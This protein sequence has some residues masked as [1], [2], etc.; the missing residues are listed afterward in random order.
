MGRAVGLAACVIGL[1]GAW[2]YLAP[3]DGDRVAAERLA[4]V[5][6]IAVD[7]VSGAT[8]AGNRR[9]RA[10]TGGPATVPGGARQGTESAPAI[11]VAEVGGGNGSRN[12]KP[13]D[14]EARRALV[15]SM[16]A[17][18]KRVGC[19]DGEPD[20]QWTVSTRRAMATFTERVNASLPTAEPD[21][22]LLTLLQG[23][24]GRVCGKGCPAGQIAGADGTCTPR[25]VAS[26]GDRRQ[27]AGSAG[28]HGYA[29]QPPAVAKARPEPLPGRMALAAPMPAEPGE[30]TDVQRR[31]ERAE[32]QGADARQRL[33][34]Q[35]EERRARIEA[36]R[37]RL[38]AQ[39]AQ[40]AAAKEEARQ[41]AERA[42]AEAA[43]ARR[44][45]LAAAEEQRA[46]LAQ[47]VRER[48]ESKGRPVAAAERMPPP[49]PAGPKPGEAPL[50]ATPLLAAPAALPPSAGDQ[51]GTAAA[52]VAPAGLAAPSSAQPAAGDTPAAVAAL[53]S[54]PIAVITP[55]A[56]ARKADKPR[57]DEV[58]RVAR[59]AAP[60]FVQRYGPPAGLGG[61]SRPARSWSG[62][63]SHSVFTALSRN[64]P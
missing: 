20:G 24:A 57:R 53:P 58:R 51:P 41:A 32:Q 21:Y 27:D 64:A 62:G 6:R 63:G 29:G 3:G 55:T 16:Q 42:K 14:N 52:P 26:R 15:R 4:S 5:V 56:P 19:W 25:A 39:R 40:Q 43:E 13:T 45:Q 59:T 47:E 31:R 2:L 49:S 44:R 30:A 46:R 22:I 34:A 38:D 37:Q 54:G 17:E 7:G 48:A 11:R 61:G 1:G 60:R 10:V 33:E 23:E 9:E 36:E 12:V 35:A 50:P 8:D 28:Q 18:L